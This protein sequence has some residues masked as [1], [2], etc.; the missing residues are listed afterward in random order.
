MKIMEHIKVSSMYIHFTQNTVFKYKLIVRKYVL[1]VQYSIQ[2]SARVITNS[3]P[4]FCDARPTC[5]DPCRP[6]SGWSQHV[7]EASQNNK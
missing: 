6:S 4:L 2:P 3:Y 1:Y 5:F 7:G